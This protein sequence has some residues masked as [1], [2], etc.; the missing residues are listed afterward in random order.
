MLH[1][2]SSA[3]AR[4]NSRSRRLR[5]TERAGIHTR[6]PRPGMPHARTRGPFAPALLGLGGAL[7][8]VAQA[9][10]RARYPRK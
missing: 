3:G 4:Y 7:T 5:R 9:L 8:V 2:G 1:N 6:C 10:Y